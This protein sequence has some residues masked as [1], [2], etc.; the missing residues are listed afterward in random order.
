MG[1]I[2]PFRLP[3]AIS[4]PL[5]LLALAIVS[6]FPF[7]SMPKQYFF[8]V[9]R[10]SCTALASAIVSVVVGTLAMASPAIAL[11]CAEMGELAQYDSRCWES[12]PPTMAPKAGNSSPSSPLSGGLGATLGNGLQAF[13]GTWKFDYEKTMADYRQ[14][15]EYK[16]E[17]D[18]EALSGLLNFMFG[19]VSLKIAGN[20]LQ[21]S[22]AGT[23]EVTTIDCQVN[24]STVTVVIAQCTKEGDTKTIKFE[25]VLP[26]QYMKFGAVGENDCPYCVWRRVGP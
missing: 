4:S 19:M 11:D 3:I 16:P 23:G 14:S 12:L 21:M 17:E 1:I 6:A 10:F 20:Q 13:Q 25:N 24:S 9:G 15:P 7:I 2:I 22:V 8:S 26:G 5:A 18:I